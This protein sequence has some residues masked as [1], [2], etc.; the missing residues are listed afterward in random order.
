MAFRAIDYILV[1]KFACTCSTW[2]EFLVYHGLGQE[3][4]ERM[5]NLNCVSSDNTIVHSS[6]PLVQQKILGE[7]AKFLE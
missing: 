4:V 6:V 7:V 3:L 5:H 1:L 2:H